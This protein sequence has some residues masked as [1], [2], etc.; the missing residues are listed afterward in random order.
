MKVSKRL[1]SS[2]LTL[3]ALS[4]A[5][6]ATPTALPFPTA[7]TPQAV[8]VGALA[9][10]SANTQVSVTVAL[11]LRN[12]DAAEELL[13][14]VSSPGSAQYHQFLTSEQFVARFAPTQGDFKGVRTFAQEVKHIAAVN[15]VFGSTILQEKP[16][17]DIGG[18]NGP[19]P[20][21]ES[22]LCSTA[23]TPP[24]VILKISP[25]P[26]APPCEVAP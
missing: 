4:S 7:Q 9:A 5:M 21:V 14:S 2:L 16:P 6:A 23:N 25:S 19:E 10:Q 26:L 13:Q 15:Y 20:S 24:E 11:S 1:L 12:I 22:K 3:G 8:D 17:V 18:E